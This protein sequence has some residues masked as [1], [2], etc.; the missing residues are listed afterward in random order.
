MLTGT[1]LQND[2]NELQNLLHFLLPSV[3]ASEG[4][5]DMAEMLQV[6]GSP[7]LSLPF[8]QFLFEG[9]AEMLHMGGFKDLLPVVPITKWL[10][11]R[12][13]TEGREGRSGVARRGPA[14][15]GVQGGA[16]GGPPP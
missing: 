13:L 9:M 8:F 14:R 4:F 6:G 15:R 5:E 7:L 12:R 16:G 3:F 11:L 10:E 1:P 2:L